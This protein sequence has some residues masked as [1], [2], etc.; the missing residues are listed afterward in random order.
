MNR[1]VGYSLGVDTYSEDPICEFALTA[2]CYPR[3]GRIIASL[4]KRAL[5]VMEG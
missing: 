1:S 4:G 5:F 3:I 2:A